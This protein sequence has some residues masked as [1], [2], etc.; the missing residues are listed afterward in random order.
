MKRDI[1]NTFNSKKPILVL[2]LSIITAIF[3]YIGQSFN[4]YYFAVVGAVFEFLWLPMIASLYILPILSLF[5][6]IKEKFN[7][8]SLYLYSFL[9]LIATILY[10]YLIN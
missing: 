10:I 3:W 4:V 9:I 7:L 2:I 5:Y 8:I 6:L 1:N